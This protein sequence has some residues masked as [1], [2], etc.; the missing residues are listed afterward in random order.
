MQTEPAK[1]EDDQEIE[2]DKKQLI[3]MGIELGPIILFGLTYFIYG[4]LPATAVL[5]GASVF[6]VLLSK[7]VLNHIGL[8][9]VI[10]AAVAVLFGGMTL[11]FQDTVFIKMKPTI[12]Y[13]LF[14]GLL[15]FGLI[16]G[17]NFLASLF[18]QVFNLTDEG[19]RIL[20][21]RWAVFFITLAIMNEFIWRN[22]SEA[23]W[24][25]LKLFGFTGSTI[26]F[27]IAQVG[28]LSR[29]EFKADD[30]K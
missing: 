18:G 8:M 15:S 7:I 6:A 10:T 12:I 22:F 20:T 30:Q 11:W 14:G 4:L 3:K 26:V 1:K 23:T 27:A 13:M 17:R 28:L 5:I 19:W 24:V 21:I 2:F 29:Y 25:Y 9:P 16:T